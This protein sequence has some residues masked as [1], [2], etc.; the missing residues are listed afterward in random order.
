M[1][2]EGVDLRDKKTQS[3]FELFKQGRVFTHVVTVCDETLDQKCPIF[4]GM[5]HRLHLPFPDPAK[6]QGT[7]EEKLVQVRQIRNQIK[8]AVREFIDWT[9]TGQRSHLGAYQELQDIP[10]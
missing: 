1:L 10:K 6:V 5:T 8:S 7:H 3:A 4:P 2:E 9:R